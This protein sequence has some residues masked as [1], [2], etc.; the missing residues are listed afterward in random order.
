MPTV[1][2]E[3][4]LIRRLIR[5]NYISI[6][7]G[8]ADPLQGTRTIARL[9]EALSS[10]L[11]AQRTLNPPKATNAHYDQMA[12]DLDRLLRAWPDDVPFPT[13]DPSDPSDPDY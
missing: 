6:R 13:T 12:A 10:L 5:L 1:S 7:Q 9:S 2:P 11:R 3:V 8:K 4:R